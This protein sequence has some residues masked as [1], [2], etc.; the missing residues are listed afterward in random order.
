[1]TSLFLSSA[2]VLALT[3]QNAQAGQVP[4]INIAG[5]MINVS[6]GAKTESVSVKQDI[7]K[8][9][10]LPHIAYR[11]DTKWAVWDQRGLTIRVGNA[12]TS[13]KLGDIAVSPKAFSREQI[14][15]NLDLFG[16]KARYKESDSLSGSVRI[17]T[18]CYFVP[19]WTDSAGQTWLEAL[20]VVDLADTKPKPTFLGRFKGVTAAYKPIDEKLFIVKDKLAVVSKEGDTWGLSSFDDV[21]RSFEFSPLGSNLVSY[22]RGGYFIESTSYGTYIV[23]QIDLGSGVRKNL[24]ETRT[25]MVDLSDGSTYAIIRAKESTVVKNLKTGGQVTHGPNAYIAPI[26]KYLLVWTRDT[27]T[28]AWLYEPQRWTTVATATN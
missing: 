6:I 3:G 23:G 22:F 25:K 8:E 4:K 24:F 27:R 14:L 17:G 16:Q 9:K 19:R 13:T 28:T 18:L 2:F 20:V 12:A 1:M 26:D 15:K 10:S 7:F 21:N 5:D 11:R